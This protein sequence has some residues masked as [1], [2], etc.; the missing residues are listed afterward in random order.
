MPT[1]HSQ[2]THQTASPHPS[3][4]PLNAA[5]RGKRGGKGRRNNS[6]FLAPVQEGQSFVPWNN[7]QS[8]H[9]TRVINQFPHQP[10]ASGSGSQQTA[11]GTQAP[12]PGGGPQ[13]NSNY[14]GKKPWKPAGEVA[15]DNTLTTNR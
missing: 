5:Q 13:V 12:G 3:G 7:S 14:K 6:K 2:V 10:T 15:K 8:G 9:T 11:E 1:A 4:S